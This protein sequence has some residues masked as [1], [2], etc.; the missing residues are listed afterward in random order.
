VADA[1]LALVE[2]HGPWAGTSGELLARITPDPRPPGWP[3]APRALSGTLKRLAPALRASGG[4]VVE[5]PPRGQTRTIVLR[6]AG[7]PA[8]KRVISPSRPSRPS[9]DPGGQQ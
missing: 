5:F 4:L 6:A 7:N 1:V 8:D 9:R 2:E 3:R